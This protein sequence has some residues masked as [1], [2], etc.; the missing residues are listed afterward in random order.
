MDQPGANSEPAAQGMSC[1]T[2]SLRSSIDHQSIMKDHHDCVIGREQSNENRGVGRMNCKRGDSSCGHSLQRVAIHSH[3]PAHGAA[4]RGR[5]IAA[6]PTLRRPP[7][8]AAR[9]VSVAVQRPGGTSAGLP[10]RDHGDGR[11]GRVGRHP[12][13]CAVPACR[14]VEPVSR[15]DRSATWTAGWSLQDRQA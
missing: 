2:A 8:L 10:F 13:T 14:W 4:S 6:M 12:P 3:R 11:P 9:R 5:A 7:G 15:G 1:Q